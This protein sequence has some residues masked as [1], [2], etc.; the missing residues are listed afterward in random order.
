MK[1]HIYLPDEI[2]E[3]MD[4][5]RHEYGGS[6]SWQIRRALKTTWAAEQALTDCC[7][8]GIYSEFTSPADAIE[9][10]AAYIKELAPKVYPMDVIELVPD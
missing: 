7:I 3:R 8:A 5:Y 9:Q 4:Q 2:T 10:M 1:F 6:R